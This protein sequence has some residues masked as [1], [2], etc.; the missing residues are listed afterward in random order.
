M[1]F[2]LANVIGLT[3][4][5][6]MVIAYA[7]SNVAKI[8]NFTLFNLL[9]LIGSLLLLYSLTVHFNMASLA[10]EVVWALIALIG[11]AKALRKGETS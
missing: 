4:S 10:L 9:N 1:T 7:Y 3:G 2:D 11:L 8:L 6:L 5:A